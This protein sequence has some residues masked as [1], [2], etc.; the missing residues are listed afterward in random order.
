MAP[1]N[2]SDFETL[3]QVFSLNITLKWKQLKGK[4]SKL[5]KVRL[6]FQ[7]GARR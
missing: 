1:E 6:H 7:T 5:V 3:M 2:P 4:P